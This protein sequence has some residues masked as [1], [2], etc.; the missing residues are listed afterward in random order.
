MRET[1]ILNKIQ[2]LVEQLDY[3]EAY[4]TIVTNNS[5]YNMKL[6]KRTPAGFRFNND[7]DSGGDFNGE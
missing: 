5:E 1:T 2:K 7:S 4:I 3:K 6:Q